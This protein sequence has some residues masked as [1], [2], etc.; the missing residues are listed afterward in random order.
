M[1]NEG[2]AYGLLVDNT[3]ED[4]VLGMTAGS[5]YV[6]GD[7]NGVAHES[8]TGLWNLAEY[9]PKHH[10]DRNTGTYHWRA[11]QGRRRVIPPQSLVHTSVFKRS[12]GYAARLPPD[13]IPTA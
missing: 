12:S 6:P 5:H 13:A 8:L 10:Y 7:E 3:R 11:N 9:I 1:L 4:E 2:K